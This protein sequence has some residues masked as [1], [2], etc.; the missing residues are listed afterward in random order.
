MRR[1]RPLAA[2]LLGALAPLAGAVVAV[3]GAVAAQPRVTKEVGRAGSAP[4]RVDGDVLIVLEKDAATARLLDPTS[5]R[6]LTTLP[7]GPFP[8]EVAVSP[9]GR[10]AV[11]ADYGAQE[12]GRTLTVIDL[13]ARRVL[14]T[15]SLGEYRRPHG[16]VWI[17]GDA[18]MVA[19]TAEQSQAVLV[20]DV[21]AGAVV[22][23]IPTAQQGTHML[24][25]ASGGRRAWTANIGSGSVTLVDLQEGRVVRTAPVG[26]GPEAIDVTPDGREVWA[27]DRQQDVI[28]ILDATTLDSLG[29]LPTGRFPNRLKFTPDGR[30]A[31]VSNAAASTITVYDARARRQVATVAL[32]LGAG[33]TPSAPN[34]MNPTGAS[35]VPLGIQLAPDGRRAWIAANATGELIELAIPTWRIVRRIAAG[36]GP[37]GMA[38][39]PAGDR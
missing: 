8:H 17:E 24:A 38:Y 1:R 23:A 21:D 28:R 19:V 3:P 29:A 2:F 32:P 39:V 31:L 36:A 20:V 13:R 16:I 27:A 6:T 22:R 30:W 7:T 5:G 26:Q 14:R 9:D 11:V 12:P 25:L 18:P 15:V 37:D 33:R 10:L 4:T 34:A 35:V